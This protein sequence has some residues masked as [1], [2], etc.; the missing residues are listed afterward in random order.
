MCRNIAQEA[1]SSKLKTRRGLPKKA[2]LA[3]IDGRAPEE[4]QRVL[5]SFSDK[6]FLR[7]LMHKLP[8]LEKSGG[9]ALRGGVVLK[10][11]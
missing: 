9:V 11:P 3:V 6:D 2:V 10:N 7:D 4:A 5:L 1:C 8:E